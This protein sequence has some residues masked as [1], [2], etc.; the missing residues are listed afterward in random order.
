MRPQLGFARTRTPAAVGGEVRRL[1][2]HEVSAPRREAGTLFNLPG[3][4]MG[5][6]NASAV[7]SGGMR[8]GA[9]SLRI[10]KDDAAPTAL[11]QA[12]RAHGAGVVAGNHT[13]VAGC[14]AKPALRA[15]GLRRGRRHGVLYSKQRRPNGMATKQ[16]RLVLGRRPQSE[17]KSASCGVLTPPGVIVDVALL[18]HIP[19]QRQQRLRSKAAPTSNLIPSQISAEM[20]PIGRRQSIGRRHQLQ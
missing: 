18:L 8:D 19:D 3:A 4:A 5:N 1:R 6:C 2:G 11:V 16:Q 14:A 20:R 12:R 17:Q 10:G 13:L 15:R 9:P 7:G